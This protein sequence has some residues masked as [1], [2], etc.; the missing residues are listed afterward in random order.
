M[1]DLALNFKKYT[2]SIDRNPRFQDSGKV[3]RVVGFLIEGYL[4]GAW[5]GTICEIYPNSGDKPFQAEVVGFK[6]K[7]VLMMPLGEIHGVGQGAR[8]VLL[9]RESTVKVGPQLLGRILN[10]LGEPMDKGGNFDTS[11]EVSFYASPQNP[12]SRPPIRE[13]LDLGIKCINGL[14]TAGQGQRV[15]IMAGS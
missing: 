15:G 13:P 10:G 2:N 8:I 1:S 4:P 14:L 9:H 3:T 7:S 5:L 12:L 6:E 11:D